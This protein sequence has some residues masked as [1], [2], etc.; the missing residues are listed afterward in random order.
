MIVLL[1]AAAAATTAIDAEREF[2]AD[3]QNIG[4]WA[5]FRKWSTPD[6]LMFV[7]EPTNAHAFLKD[8]K[9]PAVAVFWWP[10]RSYV[11]CDGS[12]AVNTGPWV[13]EWGKSVGYFSTVWKREGDSWRWV[14]DAGDS[15]P[16][17]RAEGGDIKARTASCEGR[18]GERTALAAVPGGSSGGGESA[19]GT[20]T[21]S[22]SVG[23]KGERHFVARLWNGR[24][25]E[26][27]LEDRV[28]AAE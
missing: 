27:V 25:F 28:S 23:P 21:W 7:P 24:A 9:E 3:A 22:W 6:A 5:A 20:L 26:A 15:L 16:T 8:R 10:G 13:R 19:D 11:S 4:Q 14:Y 17:P 2:A 1:L 18:P 12:V